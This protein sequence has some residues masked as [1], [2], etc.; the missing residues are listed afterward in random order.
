MTLDDNA[1]RQVL[2]N[3]ALFTITGFFREATVPREVA[4]KL[5]EEFAEACET[6]VAAMY[7]Q[8]REC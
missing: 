2:D 6:Y 5:L 4:I 8:E 1:I 7:D 3:L